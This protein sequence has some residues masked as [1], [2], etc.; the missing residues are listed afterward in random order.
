MSNAEW[1]FER[2]RDDE[3]AKAGIA[4]AKAF[5][6]GIDTLVR[7][8][9]QNCRDAR[10][11]KGSLGA[12]TIVFHLEELQGEAMDDYLAML[13]WGTLKSHLEASCQPHYKTI[14]SKLKRGLESVERSGRIR[15]LHISDYSTE[16]LTGDEFELISNYGA[17]LRSEMLSNKSGSTSGGTYGLGK[18]NYWTFSELSTVLFHSVPNDTQE[19]LFVGRCELGTHTVGETTFE[20]KG[21]FG[22]LD[23][24]ALELQPPKNRAI[25][26]RGDLAPSLAELL[27]MRRDPKEGESGTTI[28]IVGFAV[29]PVGEDEGVTNPH[30]MDVEQLCDLINESVQ[31]HYWPALLD[32][33]INVRVKCSVN[34]VPGSSY[35]PACVPEQLPLPVRPFARAYQDGV[36]PIKVEELDPGSSTALELDITVPEKMD[37]TPRVPASFTLKARRATAA[38]LAEPEESRLAG[39]IARIRGTGMVIDY[40]TPKGVSY[41]GHAVLIAGEGREHPSTTDHEVEEFLQACEKAAHDDWTAEADEATDMYVSSKVPTVLSALN[42][43]MKEVANALTVEEEEIG[44]IGDDVSEDLRRRFKVGGRDLKTDT[45]RFRLDVENLTPGAPDGRYEMEATLYRSSS[46]KPPKATSWKADIV[47]EIAEDG[48]GVN[49]RIRIEKVLPADDRVKASVGEG[50]SFELAIPRDMAEVSFRVIS[51]TNPNV[52]LP[53]DM[54]MPILVVEPEEYS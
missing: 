28:T 21:T 7:E 22:V 40:K 16:G 29:P 52:G 54:I 51:E 27:A 19:P 37:G 44:V 49:E 45:K 48:G 42:N 23:E 5:K 12:A 36:S 15:L 10:L 25:A 39:K 35:I 8:S 41:E 13:G 47:I 31:M 18:S 17:L 34:G 38:E 30:Q 50:E 43:M 20:G 14:Y 2:G 9:V 32:G 4:T 11:D 46:T 6:V 24:R 53:L 33:S 26:I 1:V 3:V